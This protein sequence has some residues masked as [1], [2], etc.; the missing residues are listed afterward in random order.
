MEEIRDFRRQ[1]AE[2]LGYKN[3]M[4]MSMETKM[5]GSVDN[6]LNLLNRLNDSARAAQENEIANLQSYAEKVGFHRKLEIQDVPYYRRRQ[7]AENFDFN[8][9][10][11]REYFPLNK[12]FNNMLKLAEKL[13]EIKITERQSP[14]RWHEDV[15]FFDIFDTSANASADPLGG[16]Y[17]DLYARSEEKLIAEINEGWMVNIRSRSEVTETRPMSAMIFNFVNLPEK[18]VLLSVNEVH[19]LFRKFGLALQ[20][21]LTKSRYNELAGTSNIEW[22]AVETVGK[23]MSNLL[24]NENILKSITAHYSNDD[25]LPDKYVTAFLQN[26]KHLAGFNLCRELYHSELDVALHTRKDFWMDLE[27]EIYSKYH[28]FELDKKDCH[29]CSFSPI[30]SGEWGAAYYSN[31]WSDV[32][33]ADVYSAFWEASKTQNE[34]DFKEVGKRFRDTFLTCGGTVSTSEV[35]RRFRGRDPS[36]KALFKSL[37]LNEQQK[38]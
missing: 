14:N 1:K 16:F 18:S 29:P 33:A 31:V 20:Q 24:Y 38:K 37:G 21:I 3:Y 30:F 26:R 28:V 36:P 27:K 34:N 10:V 7:L 4:E 12:V 22:D 17:A 25:S 15:K 19:Q 5:A 35:F 2:V 8:E 9:D 32:L 23:V 6:V 13:F 11:V